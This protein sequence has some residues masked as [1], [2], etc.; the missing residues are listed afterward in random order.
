MFEK[1]KVAAPP[2]HRNHLDRSGA[3]ANHPFGSL[4]T[5]RELTCL[6]WAHSFAS[7]SRDEFAHSRMRS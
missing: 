6:R 5:P 1:A 2:D 7:S 4:A 3:N